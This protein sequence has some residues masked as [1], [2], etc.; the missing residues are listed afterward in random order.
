MKVQGREGAGVDITQSV[1]LDKQTKPLLGGDAGD[2]FGSSPEAKQV[3]SKVLDIHKNKTKKEDASRNV[4]AAPASKN[5]N[6]QKDQGSK[7]I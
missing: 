5:D 4:P 2:N 3:Q 7:I 6:T 1:N